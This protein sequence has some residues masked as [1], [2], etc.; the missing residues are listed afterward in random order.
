MADLM[1]QLVT[2]IRAHRCL[3]HPIFHHWAQ[4]NPSAEVIGAFFHHQQ[5]ACNAT[6]PGR[7]FDQGLTNMD[8]AEA[9]Q[10]LKEIV[11]SEED[12]GPHLA[13]MAGFLMNRASGRTIHPDLDDKEG[14]EEV[15]RNCSRTFFSHLP[16][17]DPGPG[18]LKQDRAVRQ[19]LMRRELTDRDSTYR[20]IGTL[21]AVEMLAAEHV[22]PGEMKCLIESGFYRATANDREMEY[23]IEHWGESGA[24]AWHSE[25]SIAAARPLMNE[26][27]EPL[28]F[29][30]AAECLDAISNLWDILDSTLLI[31]DFI[32]HAPVPWSQRA[33]IYSPA[34]P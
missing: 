27:T 24:E 16:G 33:P 31:P 30:G 10:T 19:V 2:Y 14:I 9:T 6:R 28:M 13:R 29:A 8:M 21:V 26:E 1:D 32:A 15:M 3:N 18:F 23:L 25:K 20:N 4:V 12:H 17:Y 34:A 22:F 5:T 11:A 7:N